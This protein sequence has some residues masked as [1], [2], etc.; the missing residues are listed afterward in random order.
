M[1]AAVVIAARPVE[2]VLGHLRDAKRVGD[3]KW[4]ARC[5]AYDDTHASLG[6]AEGKDGRALLT[7][8][9]G[10]ETADV[11]RAIGLQMRDLFPSSEPEHPPADRRTVVT[12]K[13]VDEDG[14]LLYEAV[15]YEPKDL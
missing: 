11:V 12:Y 1:S 4:S 5:P 15:R 10:C 13:Y 2:T 14:A 6:I 8:R 9:A 3:G 7:C